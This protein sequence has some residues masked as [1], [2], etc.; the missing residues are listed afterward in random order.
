MPMLHLNAQ[1]MLKREVKN[2]K[3]TSY[4][5]RFIE[6]LIEVDVSIVANVQLESLREHK[7][8]GNEG[9]RAQFCQ[10]YM[11]QAH[12]RDIV[13]AL[14]SIGRSLQGPSMLSQS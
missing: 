8:Q 10:L 14:Q 3:K 12:P 6:R 7:R 1:N 2:R 9:G 13:Q 5:E 11:L 4:I